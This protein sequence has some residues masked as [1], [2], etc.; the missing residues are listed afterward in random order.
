M[1]TGI[2]LAKNEKK[3]IESAISSLKFCQ[4]V[5]VVD[6]E[7]NDKTAS[8]AKKAGARVIKS[9]GNGFSKHRTKGM[10]AAR[11]EWV[12]FVDA[13]EHVSPELESEI[14]T[15]I[16]SEKYAAYRIPRIDIFWGKKLRYGEVKEAATKGIIR[17]MKKGSGTWEHAVHEEFVTTAK[18][19]RLRE[20]LV[21]NAH[22]G[23]TD[24]LHDINSYSTIRAEELY[25]KSER[26]STK[27][28]MI[29]PFGKFIY[30]YFILQGYRDGSAGFAYSFM[31]SFHSF[32]VRSKVYL[33]QEGAT[34]VSTSN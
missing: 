4:E 7:S 15:R 24:F 21:H 11:E 8:I 22:S 16:K 29:K 14:L 27:D 17:L 18:V 34:K 20:H 1:L 6:N 23:V 3:Q 30:T 10:E 31:M 13:D 28:L 26:I 33:L 9:T 5:I 19:G 32:L 25:T 12:L 2:I